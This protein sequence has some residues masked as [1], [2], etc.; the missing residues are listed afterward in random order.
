MQHGF[1][2]LDSRHV[3]LARVLQLFLAGLLALSLLPALPPKLGV[4]ADASAAA[5]RQGEP[6]QAIP[7]ASLNFEPNF[8][9]LDPA[10]RFKV[11]ALGGTVFLT[12]NEL[13]LTLPIAPLSP[14]KLRMGLLSLHQH[15]TLLASPSSRGCALKAATWTPGCWGSSSRQ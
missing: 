11:D 13:V 2:A 9:Q 12:A 5:A 14:P 10:V 4:V 7:A 6:T 1:S 3:P 8:G 15:L